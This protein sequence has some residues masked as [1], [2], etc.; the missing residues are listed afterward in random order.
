M[1]LCDLERVS[2]NTMDLGGVFLSGFAKICM[3]LYGFPLIYIDLNGF[4]WI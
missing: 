4:L 1:D 2:W 3:D